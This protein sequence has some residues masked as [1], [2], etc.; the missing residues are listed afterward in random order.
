MHADDKWLTEKT[1]C[2]FNIDPRGRFLI[3]AGMGS[4]GITVHAIDA[5]TGDLSVVKRYPVGQQPNWV[6]IVDR[7]VD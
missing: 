2:G 7:I 4:A 5:H 1:L 3:A 6:E